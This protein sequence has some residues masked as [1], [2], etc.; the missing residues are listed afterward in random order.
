MQNT[1][2]TLEHY[3]DK[4]LLIWKM[5]VASGLSWEIAKLFGSNHPYLAPLSVILCMQ[6]TID[7]SIRYSWH[8]MVGTVIGI[9]STIFI[10]S[11]LSVNGWTLGLLILGGTF[12]AKWMKRDETVLHQVA[13][14]ILLVFVFEHKTKHYAMDRI[15]DTLIGA[16]IA[17]LIQM[18]IFPPNY[19]KQAIRRFEKFSSELSKF[20]IDTG[21]WV[22]TGCRQ[23]EGLALEARVKGL[24]QE[25]HQAKKDITTASNSLKY[26]PLGKKSKKILEELSEK[27]MDLKKGYHYLSNIVAIFQE[28]GNEGTM[29]PTEQEIWSHQLKVMSPYFLEE[30][31]QLTINVMI[32][33]E[34]EAQKYH[35]SLYQATLQL[36]RKS[37]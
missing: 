8:R 28:W 27:M 3:E 33:P 7:Q 17:I 18:L 36:V 23:A 9:V 14:T 6:T 25:L 15:R 26:N 20:F 16:M 19:T 21:E 24:L 31:I 13:L 4:S 30:N 32:Q 5:A 2:E 29:T 12:I 37:G 11:K 34:F 22:Q 35:I 1:R 10:A